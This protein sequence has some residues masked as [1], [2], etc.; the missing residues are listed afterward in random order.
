MGILIRLNFCITVGLTH[1]CGIGQQGFQPW[2][3]KKIL[4]HRRA[5][6]TDGI[7]PTMA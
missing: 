5:L 4:M 6:F 3:F 2:T 7:D 1:P